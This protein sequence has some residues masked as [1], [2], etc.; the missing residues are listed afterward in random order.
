MLSRFVLSVAGIGLV[1]IV[2]CA[3][4]A[5]RRTADSPFAEHEIN[6]VVI[7]LDRAERQA[8]TDAQRREMLHALDDLR[9]LDALALGQRR[10]AD[11]ENR[12]GQWTLVQLM[13]KYFVPRQPCSIDEETFYRHAQAS[14]ARKVVEQ[15]IHALRALSL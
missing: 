5:G 15:H 8:E 12:P 1:L 9:S 4:R 11:Y 13:Q 14:E 2:A 7:Y 3:Q 10:Y 6:Q